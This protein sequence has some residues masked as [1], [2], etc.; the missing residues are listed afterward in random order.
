MRIGAVVVLLSFVTFA[1]GSVM[2][3]PD[4]AGP[5][6]APAASE[7]TAPASDQ[8]AQPAGD[9]QTTA[10][11]QASAPQ[12]PDAMV[13]KNAMMITGSRL[14][15]TQECHS[16]AWWAKHEKPA[17]PKSDSSSGN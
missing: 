8:A 17:A 3:D 2:A 7:Q 6:S 14:G 11:A 13:C 15:A 5:A 1:S 9:A 4:T 16:A 12:N 10:V